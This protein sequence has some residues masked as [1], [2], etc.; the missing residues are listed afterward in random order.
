[1]ETTVKLVRGVI[2]LLC[3]ALF[4]AGAVW[5]LCNPAQETEN[6]MEQS[7]MQEETTDVVFAPE[8]TLEMQKE[9]ETQERDN[10]I[11]ALRIQR[12]TSWQQLYHAVEQL[13]FAEKQQKLH[14]YA[15]LQYKE[16]RLELLLAAKGMEPCLAVL[17]E[18][19][20]NIIVPEALLQTEYEKLYDLVLRNTDYAEHQIILVPLK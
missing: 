14:Q 3:A 12:D 15:R 16:Q 20:A 4:L 1:M 5:N 17:E 11:A 13:E 19:Q 7:S 6:I 9:L 2:V 8:D 18:T 10:R